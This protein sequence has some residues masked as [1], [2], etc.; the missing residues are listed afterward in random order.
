[1]DERKPHPPYKSAS[2]GGKP[3]QA[4]GTCWVQVRTT[5]THN[6][7]EATPGVKGTL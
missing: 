2:A 3:A 4:G 6:I 5:N 1:M 7:T